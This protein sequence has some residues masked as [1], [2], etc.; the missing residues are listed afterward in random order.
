MDFD[1]DPLA[2]H[3][4]LIQTMIDTYVQRYQKLKL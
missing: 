4:Q 2:T 3:P 1:D